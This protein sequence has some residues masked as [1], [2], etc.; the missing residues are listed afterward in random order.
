MEEMARKKAAE[1]LA[2]FEEKLTKEIQDK[3]AALKKQQNDTLTEIKESLVKLEEDERKK[4]KQ[5]SESKLAELRKSLEEELNEK[6]KE[7]RST[8]EKA[9]EELVKSLEEDRNKLMEEARANHELILSHYRNDEE[10]KLNEEKKKLDMEFDLEV[11]K[12]KE[13]LQSKLNSMKEEEEVQI[14]KLKKE[15]ETRLQEIED[16]YKKIASDEEHKFEC[17]VK[18]LE[19]EFNSKL[20]QLKVE[21]ESEL[22]RVQTEWEDKITATTLQHK[23]SLES[24]MKDHENSM[25][26][27][28]AQFQ[29]EEDDLKKYHAEQIE[30][31]NARLKKLMEKEPSNVEQINRDFE[32]MRCEKRLIEDKY[33]SLKDK[34]LQ[35]KTDMKVAVE[36]KLQS[37]ARK[38]RENLGLDKI[39]DKEEYRYEKFKNNNSDKSPI[40]DRSPSSRVTPRIV[41]PPGGMK[42]HNRELADNDPSSD[43]QYVS[44]SLSLTLPTDADQKII[45]RAEAER[46]RKHSRMKS[47]IE[48]Y[49]DRQGNVLDDVRTQLQELEEIEEQIPA[50]SQGETYLRYPF[51]GPGLST[52]AEVDFY[53]HRVIVEQEA[54]RAARECLLQQKRELEARQNILRTNNNTSTMQQL[55]QQERDLT[56]ME[57]SLHRTR[58]LLGEKMIRLRL[59]GQTL[60][61]L[62]DDTG[63]NSNSGTS[64]PQLKPG[65]ISG[66]PYETVPFN[67]LQNLENINSE[68]REI[69]SQLSKQQSEGNAM[70]VEES[71]DMN[72]KPFVKSERVAVS[73]TPKLHRRTPSSRAEIEARIQGLREWLQK[74]QPPGTDWNQLTL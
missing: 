66:F 46:R 63:V 55:Q 69:W 73:K 59:L 30:A 39:D 68:I 27:L 33:R 20:S 26:T 32:K 64:E 19:E 7:V 12:R 34:Y 62:V 11:Q 4:L 45:N 37:R 1:K 61:R 48:K 25:A 52:S 72:F 40:P 57:V 31:W 3:I 51:H 16:N 5:E 28:R 6:E 58:A 21:K 54:V 14:D 44:T 18:K 8:N 70:A 67:V 49:R 74:P 42:E 35:L 15:S 9:V 10:E 53:R 50:N 29:H 56:E 13:M 24:A 2:V 71:S 60:N 36:R 17:V 65:N 41:E 43:D 38:K 47:K 22:K 23:S